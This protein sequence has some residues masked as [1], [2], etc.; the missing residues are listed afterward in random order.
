MTMTTAMVMINNL[1]CY[2]TVDPKSHLDY[3]IGYFGGFVL[4]GWIIYR[5]FTD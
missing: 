1:L 5:L 2:G 4:I 3:W